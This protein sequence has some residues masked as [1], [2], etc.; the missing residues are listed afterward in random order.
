MRRISYISDSLV[1]MLSQPMQIGE[2]PT[3]MS[4]RQ[5]LQNLETSSSNGLLDDG[6]LAAS[7]EIVV[8]LY[9]VCHGG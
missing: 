6:F 5:V 7:L 2:R 1:S 4:F 3:T 9:T 8:A